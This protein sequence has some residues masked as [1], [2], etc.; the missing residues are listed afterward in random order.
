[1]VNLERLHQHMTNQCDSLSL[2]IIEPKGRHETT[3]CPFYSCNC[4]SI[5]I[6]Q[7]AGPSNHV[8]KVSLWL[9]TMAETSRYPLL[10][11][12]DE[13]P[14]RGG[15]F[16]TPGFPFLAHRK[17]CPDPTA[18][19]SRMKGY[20]NLPEGS[21]TMASRSRTGY[22]VLRRCWIYWPTVVHVVVIPASRGAIDQTRWRETRHGA[23]CY[24][25]MHEA[26]RHVL[27]DDIGDPSSWN[28][29]SVEQDVY[30]APPGVG[31]FPGLQIIA[32]RLPIYSAIHYVDLE[33]SMILSIRIGVMSWSM[34]LTITSQISQV[35]IDFQG[36][37][38]QKQVSLYY[39]VKLTISLENEGLGHPRYVYG[40]K[41]KETK[42]SWCVI[43]IPSSRITLWVNDRR[44]SC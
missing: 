44:P 18:A 7:H 15:S 11:G 20:C 23:V 14:V 1:M 22:V 34:G 43:A 33:I 37:D 10:L 39:Y 35:L 31:I 13:M 16:R 42:I 5:H 30:R 2:Q 36:A 19:D 32:C 6:C 29:G 26:K 12:C 8:D 28:S 21:P 3:I 25:F 27:W 17:G 40:I 41:S 4:R 9:M 24:Q 38:E